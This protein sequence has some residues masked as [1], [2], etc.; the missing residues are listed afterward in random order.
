MKAII[1]FVLISLTLLLILLQ[2]A[3]VRI[4][5]RDGIT[6]KIDYSFLTVVLART[7]KE[8]K[9][10]S[11]DK[12]KLKAPRG[13]A[14]YKALRVIVPRSKIT[15]HHVSLSN[16]ADAPRDLFYRFAVKSSIVFYLT[17]V[18]P[19]IAREFEVDYGALPYCVSDYPPFSIDLSFDAMLFDYC[20]ALIIFTLQILKGKARIKNAGK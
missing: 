3:A 7:R 14:A 6:I 12:R 13:I 9:E 8:K 10:K 19:L 2:H 15:L 11:P 16:S 18:I 5:I 17:T 1:V 20:R 4:I